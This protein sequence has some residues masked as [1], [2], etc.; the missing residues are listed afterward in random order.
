M[1]T[2]KVRY[3]V[4]EVDANGRTTYWGP[5]PDKETAESWSG[6]PNGNGSAYS[7][8]TLYAAPQWFEGFTP[9]EETTEGDTDDG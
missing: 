5:F 7:V 6:M 3:I 8:E 1:I 4:S 9:D 2:G